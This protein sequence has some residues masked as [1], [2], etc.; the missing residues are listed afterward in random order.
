MSNRG[1][2]RELENQ[3]YRRTTRRVSFPAG[4]GRTLAGNLDLPTEGARAFLVFAHCFT[5]TKDFPAAARIG[6]GLAE[7]G[8]GVLRFD[9]AG[10]GSSEGDFSETNFSS[11]LE[12]MRGA[13]AFLREQ[14]AAP[15]VMIG[16]SLGGLAALAV[17]EELP[18][19]R[20]VVTIATPSDLSHLRH[21]MGEAA[22]LA[23]KTGQGNLLVGGREYLIKRQFFDDLD[24]HRKAGTAGEVGKDLLVIHPE[25]DD[26]VGPE[27]AEAI[28][29]SGRGRRELVELAG[30]DHLLSRPEFTRSAVEAIRDWIQRLT[31]SA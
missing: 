8:Y 4:D 22:V 26:M 27:H 10:L 16:H 3:P 31:P 11:N 19:V 5:C 2:G 12:D 15:A 20:G 1:H 28:Y 30:A 18:E 13:A 7:S 14:Y 21:V 24:R 29:A 9:F 6:R 17:G 23:E 25:V